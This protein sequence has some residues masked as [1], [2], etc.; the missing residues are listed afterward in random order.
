MARCTRCGYVFITNPW[1]EFAKIYDERYYAGRGPDPLLDYS[2][3]LEHPDRTFGPTS[4]GI[5]VSGRAALGGWV[6]TA[7][8]VTAID[9]G[10]WRAR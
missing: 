10:R 7:H 9:G 4:G 3:E 6:G 1:V 8:V 2:Y 5:P